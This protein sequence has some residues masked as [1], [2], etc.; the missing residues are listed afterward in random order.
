MASI[1]TKIHAEVANYYGAK[2]QAHGQTPQGVDWNGAESQQ[3]RF[4]QLCRIIEDDSAFS[5]NDV[6]CG[7]GALYDYLQ[8][9]YTQFS[10]HGYD[11]SEAMIA[12]A[13]T[14]HP[15]IDFTTDKVC[16]TANYS[17]ASGIFNVKLSNDNDSWLSYIHATLDALHKS[18]TKGFA[19][20]CL[21]RYSD[22]DKMRDYLYYAD[23]GL[24]FDYCKRHYSKNVALLH[25]YGLYEFTIMVRA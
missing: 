17:V 22:A 11:I 1:A 8:D 2:L 15:T 6:G 18:S 16:K 5:L 7:Y 20:N 24:L 14:R 19:F 9:H 3:L 21:T 13:R 25:D 4:Q 12:A 23:P 10:Y